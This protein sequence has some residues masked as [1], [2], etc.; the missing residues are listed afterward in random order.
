MPNHSKGAKNTPR[1][2]DDHVIVD[3]PSGAPTPST[4][5]FRPLMRLSTWDPTANQDRIKATKLSPLVWKYAV[6]S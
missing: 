6:V 4:P 3:T 2:G 5:I 1:L